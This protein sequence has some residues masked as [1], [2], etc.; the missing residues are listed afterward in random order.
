[1]DASERERLVAVLRK[2]ADDIA[3]KG[4]N[5]WG[6]TMSAA[7]DMIEAGAIKLAG[8]SERWL[9]VL[10]AKNQMIDKLTARVGALEADADEYRIRATAY[11]NIICSVIE[12]ADHWRGHEGAGGQIVQFIDKAVA[13]GYANLDAALRANTDVGEKS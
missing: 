11:D 5:G 12:I 10:N 3:R 4:I 6:N 1:M 2:Q 7:A 13:T 9:L 8:A